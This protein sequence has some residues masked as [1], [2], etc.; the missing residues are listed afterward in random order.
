M[1][2]QTDPRVAEIVT[3][4]LAGR[5]SAAPASLDEL[6]SRYPAEDRPRLHSS[7]MIELARRRAPVGPRGKG[8]SADHDGF[9]NRGR[10]SL[11]A[12][13]TAPPGSAV[14]EGADELPQFEGYETVELIGKGGMGAVYEAIQEATGKRVALKV[15]L[16]EPARNDEARRRFEREVE[17][18]ARLS[19][20]DI[21][22][23]IDS[24][25]SRGRYY[26]VME[27]VEGRRLT[28]A[29]APGV[30]D[31]RAAL[32]MLARICDALDYAHQ[33]GVLH[34]DLKPTNILIDQRDEPRVLDF[35]LAKALD[36][37]TLA[38]HEMS[39]SQP[40][41]LLGTPQYMPPEQLRGQ[42]D[43]LTVRS[44]VYSL[45]V[46]G[47]E[48]VSGRLPADLSAGL[49]DFFKR[50]DDEPAPPSRWRRGLSR[51]LDAILLKALRRTPGERYAT[52]GE[53]AADLR[54]LLAGR[55]IQAR[56][57]GAVERAWRWVRR[58]RAVSVAGSAALLVIATTVTIS[59]AHARS[60]ARLTSDLV[61][62][63]TSL[64]RV[65]MLDSLP[66]DGLPAPEW[67]ARL[68]EFEQ[69]LRAFDGRPED[70]A[71]NWA[72]LGQLQ[73]AV[74]K[75]G[76]AET[77]AMEARTLFEKA[78]VQSRAAAQAGH[79]SAR[80]RHKR[81]QYAA[82]QQAYEQALGE[83]QQL[84]ALDKENAG[85]LA[86]A[87][88][89]LADLGWVHKDQGAYPEAEK[90]FEE[91]LLVVANPAF[92]QPDD[93]AR[94][95]VLNNFGMF[96]QSQGR[97]DDAEAKLREALQLR[98]QHSRGTDDE[99]V[100][101][102]LANLGTFLS[103][104]RAD[105]ADAE[106]L[107]RQALEIRTQL[108]KRKHPSTIVSLNQLGLTLREAGHYAEARPL[109]DEAM[110][111][112]EAALG[113][114]H[115][116]VAVSHCN[117]GLVLLDLEQVLGAEPQLKAALDI[118]HASGTKSPSY[119]AGLR[120]WGDLLLAQGRLDEAEA[121]ERQALDLQSGAAGTVEAG[122]THL[123]LARV[124]LARQQAAD[125]EVEARSGLEILQKT[126]V[127]S[128]HWKIAW[129]QSIFSACRAAQGDCEQA[130]A[131]LDS[132][133]KGITAVLGTENR[134]ARQ[135]AAWLRLCDGP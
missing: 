123:L 14:D 124:L 41:Q 73:Y 42:L 91:A 52:A 95:A 118:W 104:Y 92:F 115:E 57:S 129:A 131:E 17:L 34:R 1:K 71:A 27:Y 120:A 62:L 19:H 86:E 31:W 109:F 61:R 102:S 106:K 54:R 84:T 81:G 7:A 23:V 26:L 127:P 113:R 132:G 15:M 35:G 90:R 128:T 48:L 135:A 112:R 100:A 22:A 4:Y 134:Y 133:L 60:L 119:A 87:A 110:Q 2:Q 130:K 43:Q 93:P 98:Q 16:A 29:L 20:P 58:N 10:E 9:T 3:A 50:I 44:D 59:V 38:V 75:Y 96:L 121:A 77:S 49:D 83:Y 88:D 85:L 51:D 126:L 5:E 116:F 36:L 65:N 69:R 46:I 32:T 89:V 30:C 74:G 70:A 108:L 63:A 79:L 78:G 125:A 103:R 53:F 122:L 82:A 67:E 66:F 6:L 94:T 76:P 68:P 39:V 117:L 33:R 45:G 18:A 47:Y 25:L 55:P 8:S 28:E 72:R 80:A 56:H 105:Y 37:K 101:A 97:Y 107:L 13:R 12:G 99:D 114:T 64:P 111:L 40:G 21:A 24:G 11:D